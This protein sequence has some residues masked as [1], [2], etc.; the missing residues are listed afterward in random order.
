LLGGW[1]PSPVFDAS[2]WL[3]SGWNNFALGFDATRQRQ[4]LQP[5]G[6][7]DVESGR[8]LALFSAT[9][10][11]AMLWMVWLTARAERERDPV[12]RAWRRLDARYARLGLGRA[13]HEPASHWAER[14]SLAGV[15][16]AGQLREL[17]W[18]FNSWRY[19]DREPGRGA[20]ALI[21]ALDRHRPGH[22]HRRLFSGASP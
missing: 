19:A 7:G 1:V 18:R 4:M 13:P 16:T 15:D 11:L 22:Q 2:D 9:A 21:K 17:S 14:V 12:L 3:R 6:L 10:A 5:L 20:S 8:L